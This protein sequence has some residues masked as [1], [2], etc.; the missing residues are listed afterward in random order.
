MKK[1]TLLFFM[2]FFTGTILQVNA[3]SG[4]DT[5]ADALVVT[6]G[7]F[8][9]AFITA[10]TG[11]SADTS[12]LG[13]DAI[14][15][16]YTP[17][18]GG[19]INVNSCASDPD[20]VD[21]R[22]FI[23]TDGC[24]T[25]TP[26]ANDDDGCDAPNGFGSAVSDIPVIGGQEY[27]IEWDDRWEDT[28]PF[29]WVLEFVPNPTDVPDCAMNFNPADASVDIPL[30][31]NVFWEAP[32]AGEP[33][34]SYDVYLGTAID[35]LVLNTNVTGLTATFSGLELDTQYFWQV[36][37]KNVVGDATGCAITSFTT[38][39]MATP[40]TSCA[41]AIEVMPGIIND[42]F[43]IDGTGGSANQTDDLGPDALWYSYTPLESGTIEINSCISDPGGVDTRLFLYT[44]DCS[45]L[46]LV[47]NDDDGCDAPNGFGSIVTEIPVTGG[48][49]Y[50]IEWDDRWEDTNPFDWE[51]IFTPLPACP[52]PLNVTTTPTPFDA[53]ITWDAVAEAT[54]GYIVN[55]FL[56]GAD[57]MTAT[58]VYTENVPSGTLMTTATG[59]T[60][61]TGYDAYVFADCDEDG[62]SEADPNFFFTLIAC[63]SP[64]N[65]TV[66][67]ITETE[68]II[69]WDAVAEETEGYNIRVFT[70]GA[71]PMVDTPVFE[72]DVATGVTMSTA[73]GL[74]GDS[75]YDA[76]VRANCGDVNGISA[77]SQITFTTPFPDPAC[78]GL[79]LDSGGSFGSYMPN[80]N[81]TT[82]ITP[83]TPGEA[84]TVTFTYVDLESAGAGG[85]QDGCW[86]FLTIYNGPDTTFPIL[87]MTLCGEE[88][89]DGSIPDIP[90][91]VLS[92]GDS[93]TSSDPSGALTFVFSSDGSVQETGWIADITCDIFIPDCNNPENFIVDTIS[94][95]TANL[96]WDAVTG[97]LGYNWAIFDSGANPDVDTPIDSE[98]GTTALMAMATGL[99]PGAMYDAYIRTICEENESDLFGPITFTT[100]SICQTPENFSVSDIEGTTAVL[101][102]DAVSDAVSY[103][104]EVYVGG[105]NPDLDTPFTFEIE[106]TE[107]MG[108]AQGLIPESPYDAYIV[109]NCQNTQSVRLG[110]ISFESTVLSINDIDDTAFVLAPN[111]ADSFVAITSKFTVQTITVVNMLGQT[112]LNTT[113]NDKTFTIDVSTLASGAYFINASIDGV[114]V[115]KKLIKQ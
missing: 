78:G 35:A 108:L 99:T 2:A 89:G 4:G 53:L 106:T 23:Y 55:V 72:E 33:V 77:S 7:V 26:V 70:T 18:E 9:D 104:W 81:T 20:G 10:D 75:G 57:P 22:L 58:P 43:I 93:F 105:S 12:D 98:V 14:W 103:T 3:Q 56:T 85:V 54:N 11:G 62:L 5:C 45:A 66:D 16:S 107:L 51:L 113:P 100:E 25:L 80:E 19:T 52:E 63:P 50:L 102:W 34:D 94:D 31:T 101:S 82:T 68:A 21:T 110:P 28:N 65:L 111:P 76:Y 109:T 90:T 83:D 1:I 112:V 13:T 84:V 60:Q 48:Q 88:S 87:A 92:V 32:A 61:G 59:L 37:P 73:T 91:S 96:S 67:M 74:T 36:I 42:V 8:S 30:T 114:R 47:A 86:D 15:Y 44:G 6:P 71:D 97:A 24:G 27:L 69:M 29:D 115:V 41:V 46:T 39:A 17:T 95:T 64:V 38:S 40:G 79:Y 49:E